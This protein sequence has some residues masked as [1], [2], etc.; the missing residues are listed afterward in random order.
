MVATGF[1]KIVFTPIFIRYNHV[2]P[3]TATHQTGSIYK[4]YRIILDIRDWINPT[5]Q[6]NR[7]RFQIP[8]HRRIIVPEVV[9]VVSGLGIIVLARKPQV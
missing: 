5:P 3:S 8:P 2:V 4:I 9:V 6:P 7:I 1:C